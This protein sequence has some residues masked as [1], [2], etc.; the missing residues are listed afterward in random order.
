MRLLL[1]THVWLWSILE[2]HRLGQKAR[3]LMEDAENHLILSAAS[4]WEITIKYNLKRLPLPE[5]P[6]T[7]ILSRLT[8]DGIEA[9]PVHHNHV[10]AVA[11]LPRHHRDPFDRLLVAVSQQEDLPLL[12][13]DRQ[14]L[15]YDIAVIQA[16][17]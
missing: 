2:P 12:T 16:S 5:P 13:T 15:A 6:A 11:E 7:F 9:M 14:F 17:E 8:R 1:D 3:A 10:C 4:S